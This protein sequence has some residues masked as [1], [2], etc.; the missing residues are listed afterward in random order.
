[1]RSP[2]RAQ[3]DAESPRRWLPHGDGL[4]IPAGNGNAYAVRV[5][6]TG[7]FS[8][9]TAEV[10]AGDLLARDTAVRWLSEAGVPHDIAVAA[11][12]RAPGDVALDGIDPGGYSDVVF[13]CG[14]AAGRLVEDMLA[15]FPHARRLA[16]GVSVVD[17]TGRLPLDVVLERD[18][19][20][21]AT[22]D[23]SLAAPGAG[24]GPAGAGAGP[25]GAG[26][27]PSPAGGAGRGAPAGGNRVPVAGVVLSH[28]QPE[29]GSRHRLAEAHAVLADVLGSAGAARVLLD[30]RLH[31]REPHLCSTA[32][33]VETAIARCDV[34]ATT[35][36]HGLVLALKA[37]VPALAIDPVAGGGK[38]SRQSEVLGW[39]AAARVGE[40]GAGCLAGWLRWC[41]SGEART[42]AAA[43]A[44]KAQP[45]L[46]G[47]RERFTALFAPPAGGRAIPPAAG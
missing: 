38:V 36:L 37:G 22:P 10:T 35:R 26:A 16:L 32:A 46:R 5:L 19:G 45:A 43:V 8:F 20:T 12:F 21:A 30:T 31:P 34:I 14:P 9:D 29:Y 33:Q 28:D 13:V 25:A 44:G 11:N 27:G 39:P 1:V 3:P 4:V 2:A 7:W 47:T 18:S 41:L 23:L 6:V 17:G 40:A 15:R 24:T 42:V